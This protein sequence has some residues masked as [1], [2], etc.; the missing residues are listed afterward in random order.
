MWQRYYG[1]GIGNGI[2][3]LIYAGIISRYPVGV[4]QTME[5][6]KTGAI[7][8]IQIIVF[9]IVSVAIVIGVILVLEGVR[10][11]PVQYAKRMVE[12]IPMGQSSHIPLK[13]NQADCYS[14]NFCFIHDDVAGNA[15]SCS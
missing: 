4:K 14:C 13:V 10:K 3:M 11:I 8:P 2:S 6:S 15:W 12:R 7:N 1:K 9:L 5:M